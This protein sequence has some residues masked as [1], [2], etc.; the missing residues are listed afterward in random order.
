MVFDITMGVRRD[1]TGL[2][3][4]LNAL[5]IRLQPQ[6]DAILADYGV[7]RLEQRE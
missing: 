7:P 5:L 2:R 3:E 4:E 1:D 6:I